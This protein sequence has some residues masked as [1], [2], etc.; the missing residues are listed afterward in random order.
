MLK[1][2]WSPKYSHPLPKGHR[3]PMEK[4][5]LIPE[6]L[7]YEGTVTDENFFNPDSLDDKWI[8]NTHSTDYLLKLK[9]QELSKSEIRKTGFPLSESLV[10]REVHIMHGS[11]QAALYALEFGAAMNVAGG[12][13]HA[14]TNRGEGFCLLNDIGISANYL[15]DNK[16]SKKS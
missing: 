7:L 12:T 8:V 16:L 5:N 11:V 3:F 4:Y 10:E 13:H 9:N 1:I 6:Q 2:A 14:F 15:L